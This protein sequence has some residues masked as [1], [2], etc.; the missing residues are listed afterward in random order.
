M[1]LIFCPE[2]NHEI[3][4]YAEICPSCGLSLKNYLKDNNINNIENLLICPKCAWIDGG[5]GKEC[6]FA[7]NIK[8]KYCKT[9]LVQSDD[10]FASF[11]K[12]VT[13]AKKDGN[14]SYEIDFAKQYGNNQFSQ[15]AYDHR[16]AVVKQQNVER[17]IQKEQQKSLPKCP[18]CNSTNIYKISTVSKALN[19]GMFGLLGN[20]RK[21]Q[22]HC[23]NCG[24]E[25]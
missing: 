16:L 24:Y 22:F 9:P 10:T 6:N 13:Q 21:K 15:E 8:C 4:Q 23:N 14:P 20:K 19:A 5:Y 17:E 25:W 12:K 1:G 11:I 2:C 18:T 7:I 3:S